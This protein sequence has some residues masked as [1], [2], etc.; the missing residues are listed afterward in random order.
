MKKP[1]KGRGGQS[2]NTILT[3]SSYAQQLTQVNP[4]PPSVSVDDEEEENSGFSGWLRTGEGVEYMKLFVM[5][6]TLMVV[7]TMSWPHIR[8][9][10]TIASEYWNGE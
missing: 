2:T 10:Y 7:L 5:C 1:V 3:S 4:T 9:V 8:N 6:N